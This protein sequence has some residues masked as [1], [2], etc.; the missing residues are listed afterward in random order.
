M[1][2]AHQRLDRRQWARVRRQALEAA[3]WRCQGCGRA[4][5]LE[6]HHVTPL[7]RDPGQDPYALEGLATL[8]RRC[9]ILVTA[10]ERLERNPPSPAEARWDAL[11][12]SLLVNS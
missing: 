8:C 11:V 2:R 4:G 10:E 5:R 9:H 3:G 7:W 6:C 1:S 12:A